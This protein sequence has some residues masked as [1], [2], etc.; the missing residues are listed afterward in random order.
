MTIKSPSS[1][2]EFRS[3]LT[4]YRLPRKTL[5]AAVCSVLG[6][7]LT[8]Q[9][10]AASTIVKDGKTA[11]TVTQ[12]GAAGAA[13]IDVTTATKNASGSTA[14]NSFSDFNL[15]G[16][17]TVNLHLPDTATRNLVNLV[18]NTQTVINGTLNSYLAD[19]KTIGGNVFFADPN[20]VV[21]GSAGVLIVG[22]LS[23][24]T[25]TADFMNTL[26]GSAATLT[27]PVQLSP[28]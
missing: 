6:L 12:T 15:S 18:W 20:G 25:P 26:L 23:L 19:G 10:A 2:H 5:A 8:V 1:D 4:S 16:G 3:H 7:G 24:S 17:D 9:V 21:V 28:S 27:P 14:F 11:T 22:A 13:V